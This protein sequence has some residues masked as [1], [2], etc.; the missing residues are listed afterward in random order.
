MI[1]CTSDSKEALLTYLQEMVD[2]TTFSKSRY[3]KGQIDLAYSLGIIT[4]NDVKDL[5]ITLSS[6]FRSDYEQ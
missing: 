5:K 2:S 6:R 4:L 3:Y 1:T